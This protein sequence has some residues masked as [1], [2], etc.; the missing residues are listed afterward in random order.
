MRKQIRE[1]KLKQTDKTWWQKVI[2]FDNAKSIV[3]D[4]LKSVIEVIY[5][6]TYV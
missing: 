4:G 1:E 2:E 5:R 3:G 6:D